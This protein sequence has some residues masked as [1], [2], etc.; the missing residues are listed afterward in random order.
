M[1]DRAVPT[2]R[3]SV[4]GGVPVDVPGGARVGQRRVHRVEL[5]ALAEA[6]ARPRAGADD[7]EVPALG[8]RARHPVGVELR[9][10]HAALVRA[11]QYATGVSVVRARSTPAVTSGPAPVASPGGV[12]RPTTSAGP[13][14]SGVM[15]CIKA[16]E[17]GSYSESSHPSD[18]SGA[19]QVIPATWRSWSARAGYGG[20]AYAYQAP[21]S[22]QDAVVA[23]MLTHGG[24]G[25]WSPRYG[26]DYCT[27]GMP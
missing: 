16:H 13:A 24:A 7:H 14:P 23:Y 10:I 3:V 25:N 22:V 21:P 2:E 12:G 27:V 8:A 1:G 20:Y 9:A 4:Y 17:S 6:R 5:D 19:Y 11:A 26:P 18:G 15:D